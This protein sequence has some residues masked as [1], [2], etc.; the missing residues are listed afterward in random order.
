MRTQKLLSAYSENLQNFSVASI[1]LQYL[2]HADKISYR[3]IAYFLGSGD[4]RRK[5]QIINQSI[6][7]SIAQLVEHAYTKTTEC[8][9][10]KL[11]KFFG[12][13]NCFCNIGNMLIK[14]VIA[15]LLTFLV[16]GDLRR[17]TQIINQSIYSSIAQ[18]VEHAAVN[19]RVVGSSPTGG[20]II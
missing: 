6:Y 8:L 16:R 11:A 18:L 15:K 12:H 9:F 7:S 17:K 20:A 5:T 19:R 4:L 14:S 10:R 3:E 1:A 13:L 2:R